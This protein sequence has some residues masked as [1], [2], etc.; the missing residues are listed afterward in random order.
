MNNSKF[1]LIFSLLSKI[2]QHQHMYFFNFY[3]FKN[4]EYNKD[5]H[6]SPNMDIVIQLLKFKM[7]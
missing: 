4:Q 7:W 6:L 2:K 1:V 5:R 3:S